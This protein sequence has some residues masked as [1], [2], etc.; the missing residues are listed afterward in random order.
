MTEEEA[1]RD[2]LRLIEAPGY[3][4]LI[5]GGAVRD[6]VLGLP[7]HDVD[8]AT[9]MPLAQVCEVFRAHDVGK[10]KAFGLFVVVH[11][12][13]SFEVA[14]FRGET[15]FDDQGRS[16]GMGSSATFDEDAKRRDLTVNA[17]G[18][19]LRGKIHDP[20]GG[21][22]DLR[23]RVLRGVENPG[24][25]FDED[26][27]RLLRAVRFAARLGFDLDPATEE[28][29]RARAGRISS[30]APERLGDELVKMA[31]TTGDRFAEPV[32]LLERVALLEH[33]LPEV[34][35]LKGLPHDERRHPEGGVFE[36]T[37]A[38][39]R[40]SRVEDPLTHLAVLLHD[41]GK[42]LTHEERDGRP[43]YFGHEDRGADQAEEISD[44]P[45]FSAKWRETISFVARH[46]MLV[47]RLVTMRPSKVFR[48]VTDENWGV[49]RSV[50][51]C[52]QAARGEAF[53]EAE[54]FVALDRAE[55]EAGA[56]REKLSQPKGA[57]TVL[58]GNRL[59]ELTDWAIDNSV[60]DPAAVEAHLLSAYGVQRNPDALVGEGDAARE[61]PGNH[62]GSR[63][64]SDAVPT[65]ACRSGRMG[66]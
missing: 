57:K 17:M 48:L 60:T 37:L 33:L 35:A 61:H 51:F 36:H 5:V 28:A 1:A 29:L 19:D 52:D 64:E 13:W 45:R 20:W 54:F 58:S 65:K 50:A 25:R 63:D 62:V 30:A 59:M 11:R 40:A 8:I 4:A 27:V 47:P 55:K 23:R 44:R 6:H 24:D 10:S 46:H 32:L 7:M 41:V 12:G 2:V 22:E 9:D 14:G 3:T 26:P 21:L 31:S 49:L 66:G 39:C 16:A 15:R 18:L 38:A 42:G 43:T 53:R 34:Y 56:W